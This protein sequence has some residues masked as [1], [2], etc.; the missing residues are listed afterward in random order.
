MPH[1]VFGRVPRVP[2][3]LVPTISALVLVVAGVGPVTAQAGLAITTPFPSVSVQPGGNVSF[4]LTVSAREPSR[5]DLAVDG[6]PDGWTASLSGGGNEVQG[7][8][9]DAGTPATVTLTI[10]LPD[11]A[12]GGTTTVTV[13]GTSDDV[14]ARLPLDL[15][16][17]ESSGG[18]VSLESDYP[19]LHGRADT[20]FQF[21]LTLRNDTPQQLTFAL[22]AQGPA[23]WDVTI[24]PSGETRAGSVTVDARQTQRL[25]VTATPPAQAFESTYPI[26]V[27][28]TAGEHQAT[29]DL[30]VEI[31]GVVQMGFTTPDERLN[32]TANA[33]GTTDFT[34]VVANQGTSA[35][36][37]VSLG[38]S[39]PSDWEITFEPET[40]DQIAPGESVEA[41]AHIVPSSNAV[42]GDYQ[43]HMTAR[44]DDADESMDVRVT[45]ETAPIWGI[46]GIALVALTVGGLGWI[47]RRYGR[48]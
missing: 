6:L 26:S 33:G 45:V 14:T 36:T 10:D 7:A 41:V 43:V 30:A 21:N 25:E 11:D 1:A 16:V 29:A 32:T 9:V 22:Q 19:S 17:A 4:D 5:V 35:L 42:A 23:G 8:F 15:T 2:R 3:V 12:A 39:G 37:G 13:I 38:A 24:Q 46:V 44:T 31:T 34:V 27:A 28:V 48:R 18:T 47:F 20:D 40:I